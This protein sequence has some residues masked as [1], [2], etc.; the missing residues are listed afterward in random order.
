MKTQKKF[1][2]AW[3]KFKMDA[4]DYADETLLWG[5]GSI[6]GIVFFGFSG[7]VCGIIG[8]LTANKGLRLFKSDPDFRSSFEYRWIRAGRVCSVIGLVGGTVMFSG[9]LYSILYHG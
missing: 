9:F 6:M 7:I 2:L 1:P 4:D 5:L 8:I 3:L